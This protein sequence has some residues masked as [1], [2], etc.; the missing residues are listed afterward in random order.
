[1]VTDGGDLLMTGDWWL[2]IFSSEYFHRQKMFCFLLSV[3]F[4]EQEDMSL[5]LLTFKIRPLIYHT[6]QKFQDV[7]VWTIN[8]P[9]SFSYPSLRDYHFVVLL[10]LDI[11]IIFVNVEYPLIFDSGYCLWVL[12]LIEIATQTTCSGHLKKFTDGRCLPESPRVLGKVSTSKAGR[13]TY[14]SQQMCCPGMQC[15]WKLADSPSLIANSLRG[16]PGEK[17]PICVITQKSIWRFLWPCGIQF[18]TYT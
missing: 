8:S 5:C 16:A 4:S 1:M 9:L 10:F 13:Y 14:T 18:C 11:F 6:K 15:F 17:Q 2:L 7:R 12:W 3:Y